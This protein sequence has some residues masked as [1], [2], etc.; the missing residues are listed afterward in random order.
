[1]ENIIDEKKELSGDTETSEQE[2]IAE[3]PEETQEAQTVESKEPVTEELSSDDDRPFIG[4]D[5]KVTV[6]N[7]KF[8]TVDAALKAFQGRE[9]L[10]GKQANELGELRTQVKNQ[11]EVVP[12]EIDLEYDAYDPPAAKKAIDNYMTQKMQTLT[13]VVL[14]NVIQ[15]QNTAK[16]LGKLQEE[17]PDVKPE[18]WLAIAKDAE[19]KGINNL[20]D[21]FF[22]SRRD[23]IIKQA[24][25]KGRKEALK[26]ASVGSEV[27]ETLSDAGGSKTPSKDGEKTSEE[28]EELRKK[29]PTAYEKYMMDASSG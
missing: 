26:E 25:D 7:Q 24:H 4:E 15:G 10:Y 20:E 21:A 6:G 16:V 13:Q 14:R 8:D 22:L 2:T 5:G 17:N 28:V 9:S 11:T 1:M 18:E 3:L 23:Q 29:D 12:E 19:E 27:S